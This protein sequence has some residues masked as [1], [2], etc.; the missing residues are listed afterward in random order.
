MP[1]DPAELV[2][3]RLVV[4]RYGEMDGA[5]WWNIRGVLGATGRSVFSRGFAASHYFAQARV[6]CAV[7]AARCSQVFAPPG[8]LTLWNL[9]AR[10]EDEVT[11]HW[12]R[13]CQ[14]PEEWRPF[15]EDLAPRAGGDLARHL[16]EM[17]LIDPATEEALKP[18]RRSAGGKAVPLPGTGLP[19]RSTMMLLAAAFAKGEQQKPAVPYIRLD[20]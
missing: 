9:Q 12:P 7:A 14:A 19:D 8:C 18:L 15:F 3:L 2:K 13:W 11:S 5:G 1:I 20:S 16:R 4:A 17:Q 10:I 6:A